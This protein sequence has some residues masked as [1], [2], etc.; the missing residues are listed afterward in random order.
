MRRSATSRQG[1]AMPP[2][3]EAC[4]VDHVLGPCERGPG[5]APETLIEG[6]VD[7]VEQRGDVGGRAVVVRRALPDARTV[8]VNGRAP[9][10]HRCDLLLEVGPLGKAS[11]DLPLR[12][13]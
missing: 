11:T 4:L 2:A 3:P 5:E 8:E 12:E 13:L 9:A 7:G 6:D 10:P 1:A